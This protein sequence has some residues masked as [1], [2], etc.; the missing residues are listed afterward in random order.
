MSSDIKSFIFFDIE[1]TGLPQFNGSTKI[2]EISLVACSVDHFVASSGQEM[3]EIPRVLHK[4]SFCVN[5]FKRICEES[6]KITGLDNFKLE[7]ES[8]L[9][10][11]EL[12]MIVKFVE[13]L[14]QPACLV[15]HNGNGYDYPLL[16]KEFLKQK[17]VSLWVFL[18]R[19]CRFDSLR[20]LGRS[21]GIALR[22]FSPN[23]QENRSG[24]G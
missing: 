24:E 18:G 15:A 5:P 21:G 14:Q 7:H 6:T 22:G 16:R 20:F 23:L 11:R 10:V 12:E 2:M 17:I 8:R 3:P 19:F 9:G 1:G 4:L 13:R